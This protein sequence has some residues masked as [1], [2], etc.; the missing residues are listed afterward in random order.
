M[1][2][3]AF[4]LL[5]IPQVIWAQSIEFKKDLTVE[6]LKNIAQKEQKKVFVDC[7]AS[8]CGWCT[9]LNN[10]TF[11][12]EKVIALLSENFIN[13]KINM[14]NSVGSDYGW[15]FDV[16]GL[17]ALLY[18]DENGELI[19]KI[20][21]YLDAESFATET[22]YVLHPEEH[23]LTIAKNQYLESPNNRLAIYNYTQQLIENEQDATE[24]IEAYKNLH[25]DYNLQDTL[26]LDMLY[27][28]IESL[29]HPLVPVLIEEYDLI[30]SKYPGRAFVFVDFFI[31]KY[32]Y[33]AVEEENKS[34]ITETL[35]P[36]LDQIL[37][38]EKEVDLPALK[39]E[40]L[41]FYQSNT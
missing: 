15:E 16:S 8:W 37:A 30:E 3:V 33:Q 27:Y 31:K 18:I 40:I 5:F 6:E 34:I 14:D 12:D 35:F 32:A 1:K 19:K 24:I 36:F 4:L 23:P 29:N 13:V 10:T 28:E 7:W 9:E 39:Q 25:P 17:P 22:Y 26:D 20:D 2:T 41:D 38:H 21:G 11:K